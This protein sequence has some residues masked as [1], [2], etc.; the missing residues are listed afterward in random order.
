MYPN[1]GVG[2]MKEA[3]T[4]ETELNAT[5]ISLYEQTKN[6]TCEERITYFKSLAA[7]VHTKY[8][9]HTLNETRA[10]EQT[11]KEVVSY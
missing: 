5:R 9:L 4:I 7:P 11:K 6:M 1:G 2:L 10:E 8:G 3:N